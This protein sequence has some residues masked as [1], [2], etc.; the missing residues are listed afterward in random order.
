[1][2]VRQLDRIAGADGRPLRVLAT[3]IAAAGAGQARFLAIEIDMA[4]ALSLN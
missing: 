4:N 2:T 3:G 1:M